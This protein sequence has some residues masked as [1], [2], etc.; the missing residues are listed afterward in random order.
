MNLAT[1]DWT[2][3]RKTLKRDESKPPPNSFK[4]QSRQFAGLRILEG[5]HIPNVKGIL[6]GSPS[7]KQTAC[8]CALLTGL[9]QDLYPAIS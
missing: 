1:H 4:E 6:Q 7:M 5:V 2:H 3:D 8:F 9:R